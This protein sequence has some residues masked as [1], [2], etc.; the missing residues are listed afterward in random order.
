MHILIIHQAFASIDEPGGTRHHEFARELVA[1]GHRVT[2]IASPVSY[3]TGKATK[4]TWCQKEYDG[5]NL[6][7]LRAFTYSAL[8]KSFFHRVLSFFSFMVSSFLIGMGVKQVDLV[9]GTSPPIFQGFTAWLLARLKGIRFL[10]EVRDLWPAFAIALGVLKNKTIIR[11]SNWLERFLYSQADT[12]MINSPGFRQHVMERGAKKIVLIPNGAD[13]LMFSGN[14]E[15]FRNEHGLTEKFVV[16]YTG[17]HGISNDLHIV[18]QA[19]KL[20]LD[21]P[22]IYFVFVGDG[23]EKQNLINQ[24]MQLNLT[25]VLFLPSIPKK[26]MAGVLSA[27]D[28]CVAIL[29]PLDLYKTTY[30]NKVFDAMAAGKP[31]LLCIDGVVREVV[32][33]ANAGIFCQPGDFP[34]LANA[35]RWMTSHRSEVVKMGMN[36]REFLKL[37]YDRKQTAQDLLSILSEMV[38]YHG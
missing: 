31:I 12:V 7:I 22:S 37:H 20:L 26:Q 16:M 11:L 36:G 4:N 23:K 27:A 28:A 21:D 33:E 25:N 1:A 13:P 32:E 24:A 19:A 29:K 6:T 2:I 30:P 14:G 35:I 15:N 9:W 18:L 38:G 3:L 5:E 34:A 8:H 17:A 10:F